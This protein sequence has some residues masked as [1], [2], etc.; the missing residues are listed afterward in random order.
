M[1][2]GGGGGEW[3]LV[4]LLWDGPTEL[5]RG[6]EACRVPPPGTTA[7]RSLLV[8]LGVDGRSLF[9]C[10]QSHRQWVKRHFDGVHD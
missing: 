4:P 1:E 3:E 7:V 5:G 2:G 6:V 9:T 8:E 10:S